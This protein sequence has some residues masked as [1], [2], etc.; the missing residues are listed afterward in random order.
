MVVHIVMFQFKDDDNKEEYISKASNMLN[1]L[2]DSVP[3]LRS[4]EVGKNF[5][6]SDRAMDLSIIT[7]FDDKEGLQ[8]YDIH[9]EHLKVVEYIKKRATFSKAVDY[10]K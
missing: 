7:S 10:I 4:M 8:E 1:A 3:T 9:P 5:D 2:L 6:T